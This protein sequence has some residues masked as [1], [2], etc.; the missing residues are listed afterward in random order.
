MLAAA[1]VNLFLHINARRADGYH[2]LQSLIFF[3]DIGDEI[4]IEEATSVTDSLS[5]SGRFAD[6]LPAAQ[7]NLIL[8]TLRWLRGY[9]PTLP[10]LHLHL[11]KNLPIAAG[12]GGGSADAAA[13]LR[14]IEQ[15]YPEY[16]IAT[17]ADKLPQLG[18]EMPVCFANRPMLV[19]GIGEILT[20]VPDL[21]DWGILLVNPLIALPTHRV[22]STLNPDDFLPARAFEPP[23][24]EAQ[25]LHLFQYTQNNMTYAAQKRVPEIAMILE[26][27]SQTPHCLGARMSGSGA[28]CFGLYPNRESAINAAQLLQ[29]THSGWWVQSGGIQPKLT[30]GH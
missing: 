17:L 21:P 10:P 24:N 14:S 19:E 30:D 2:T 13:V 20:P 25:W 22:F 7:D 18:A 1:K 23:E 27:I 16:H 4:R 29:S 11:Q 12:L 28:S 5:I 8:Q 26:A 15:H 6:A 3:T 9:F